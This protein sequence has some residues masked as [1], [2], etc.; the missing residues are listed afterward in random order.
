MFHQDRSLWRKGCLCAVLLLT[1]ATVDADDWIRFRGPN[2]TGVSDSAVPVTF[3]DTENLK[4]KTEL[5]GPGA[6]SPIVVGDKVFLTCYSGYGVDRDDPGNIED[7]QRHLVCANRYSGDILWTKTVDA[8]QPED[9]YSGAGVPSH[10]YASHTPVSDGER[11]YAFFGKSGVYAYDLEGNEL[12]HQ[13]V[14]TESGAMR[15]GSAASPILDGDRVIVNASDE[16]EAL[17]AFDKLTGEQKWKAEAAGLGN[18]WGTPVLMEGAAGQELVIAVPGEIW[19]FNPE[20]GKLKWF[21]KGPDDNSANASLIPGDGIVY[22]IDGRGGSAVAVRI[23]GE[24]DVN[25]SHIVWEGRATGRIVTPVMYDGRIYWITQGRAY[26]I[27]AETGEDVYRARVSGEGSDEDEPA[28]DR[29]PGRG[30]GGP[31]EGRGFGRGPGGPG[32]PPEGGRGPGPGGPPGESR[33]R[34][35]GPGGPGGGRGGGFG[36]GPGD[37]ASPI[38]AGGN[39]Y[40]TVGNGTIYVY[41]AT[42]TFELLAANRFA[43]DESGFLATPAVSDG[44]MFIR[45]NK[46][47]YC[48]AGE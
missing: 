32:G 17:V 28:A 14:G 15:W 38:V 42:D 18:T 7:L 45:S 9:P 3:G 16:G 46:F 10:G 21:S 25:E 1:V 39:V 22:S 27:S 13:S 40:A 35:P 31:G 2:G 19:S 4:W 26:C 47:L 24:K 23:G 30:P 5:P 33:G 29:G 12:W 8:V 41:P 44:Q 34:G 37:Y 6:S 43:S 36:R 20:T 48:V 11:V